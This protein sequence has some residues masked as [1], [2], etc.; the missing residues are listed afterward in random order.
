MIGAV[1]GGRSRGLTGMLM[2]TSYLSGTF[3]PTMLGRCLQMTRAA[4]EV[5]AMALGR[6]YATSLARTSDDAPPYAA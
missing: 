1:G 5:S 4:A 6:G 2:G 3:L